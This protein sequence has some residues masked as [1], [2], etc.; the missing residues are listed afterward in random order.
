LTHPTTTT[1]EPSSERTAAPWGRVHVNDELDLRHIGLSQFAVLVFERGLAHY[2]QLHWTTRA[3]SLEPVLPYAIAT[4]RTHSAR[5]AVLD[6][7]HVVGDAC[8][9][10]VL[11]VR[12]TV[13]V[14]IAAAE[15]PVAA[16]AERWLRACFEP[17][18]APDPAAP[19][20]PVSFWSYGSYASEVSRSISVPV[21]EEIGFN[22]PRGVRA[23]LDRLY[24]E[25]FRPADGGQLVLWHGDPGTGKTYAL[26]ALAWAWREW[27]DL[28]YVTDPENFFGSRADYMMEVLLE[29][30]AEKPD[31]W[32]LLVLEDTG[33]LLSSAGG[34]G[35]GLSRLLNVVDGIVGQGLRILVLVTTNEPLIRLHPALARPG[36]CAARIE[37]GPF[38]ADEAEAWLARHEGPAGAPPRPTLARLFA[39]LRG[40]DLPVVEAES[41]RVGFV[42]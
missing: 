36:R 17:A 4:S 28:H 22:Y 18:E 29:E 19:R 20:V 13:R 16:E 3:E 30:D 12:E 7:A 40:D 26:R 25:R 11:L 34:G 35:P 5:G 39:H 27:C 33:D 32:R 42:R 9:A 23:G 10:A 37:F 1:E 2:A 24:D 6:L 21:W 38:D 14:R 8:L 41:T 31:R 15:Q